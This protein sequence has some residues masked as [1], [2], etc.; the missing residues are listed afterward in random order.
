M[1]EGPVELP[2]RQAAKQWIADPVPTTRLPPTSNL[3]VF[4]SWRFAVVAVSGSRLPPV[5]NA[6]ALSH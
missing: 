3:G 6:T 2:R 5:A 1:S 4:A